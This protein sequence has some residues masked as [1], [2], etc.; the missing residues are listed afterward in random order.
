MTNT[1]R[2]RNQADPTD[3][4]G[5]SPWF[6]WVSIA[7]IGLAVLLP[8]SARPV[9]AQ[10][11]NQ[12]HSCD[13]PQDQGTMNRCAHEAWQR[14]DGELNQAYQAA[15]GRFR[16][17]Q[18]TQLRRSQQA[19]LTFRDRECDFSS[20]QFEGGSMQPLIRY[21]CQD[22]LTKERLADLAAYQRGTIATAQGEDLRRSDAAL[23]RAYQAVL[24]GASG[25]QRSRLIAAE[26]AWI[27]F[28]DRTCTFEGQFG[29]DNRTI[30]R[31]KIRLTDQRT[32][33]LTAYQSSS[34]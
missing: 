7:A 22:A 18:Q 8:G 1:P 27:Q 28:R 24:N 20:G 3:R 4:L 29:W 16:G 2:Q 9:Q 25:S 17:N 12:T 26:R 33:G 14:S 11:Q 15:I 5:R 31:C 19:W 23:N 30:D 13:D 32:T 10:A 34:R 6:T 21:G